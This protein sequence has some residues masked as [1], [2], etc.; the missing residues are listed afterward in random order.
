[1]PAPRG[2]DGQGQARIDANAHL[3]SIVEFSTDAISSI[4]LDGKITSWNKAAETLFGYSRAAILHQPHNLLI[5]PDRRESDTALLDRLRDGEV[6]AHFES[7]RLAKD[8]TA[9]DVSITASAIRDGQ[10]ALIGFS[11][12]LHDIRKQK[13]AHREMQRLQLEMIYLSRW[14]MMGMMSSSLAHELNQPLTAAMSFVR[15]AWH[16][17]P[18]EAEQAREYLDLAV[19]EIKLAG[20][21]LHSLRQFIEKRELTRA[22][23]NI[24]HLLTEALRLSLFAGIQVRHRIETHLASD[25]PAV[26]MDGVQVQQVILNLLRNAI[27]ATMAVPAPHIVLSTSVQPDH[28][29]VTVR[30]NG[31]GLKTAPEQLF[32]PFNTTKAQGMGVGLSICRLIIEAHG[33]RI[34]AQSG[35]GAVFSFTLPRSA[36]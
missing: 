18:P 26:A 28:I 23:H 24:N 11:E 4:D 15:A 22:P 36:S 5:P 6:A 7:W 35:P 19:D 1:M 32:E 27:E 12:I 16:Q 14:N 21:I 29:L 31:P 17:L 10:G 33:G 13:Q 20:G 2:S 9:I 34:W 3:A 8:G 30:D 25:M